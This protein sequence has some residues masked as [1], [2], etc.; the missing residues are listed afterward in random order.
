[1]ALSITNEATLS[2][3]APTALFSAN[4]LS[5]GFDVDRDGKRFVVVRSEEDRTAQTVTVVQHWFAE[6][7][8]PGR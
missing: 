5:A 2:A 3:G 7:R 8:P 1:M 4:R 6:F